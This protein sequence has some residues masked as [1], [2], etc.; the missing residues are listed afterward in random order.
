MGHDTSGNVMSIQHKATLKNVGG[1]ISVVGSQ[2][3][4]ALAN[5]T[6]MAGVTVVWETAFGGFLGIG[7]PTTSKTVNWTVD[8]TWRQLA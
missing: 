3:T 2:T 7:G 1:T 4:T 6:N 5:D 8:I